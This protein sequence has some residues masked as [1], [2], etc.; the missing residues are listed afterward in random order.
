MYQS[1]RYIPNLKACIEE[2]SFN[3]KFAEEKKKVSAFKFVDVKVEGILCFYY[4]S[5]V[6]LLEV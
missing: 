3:L 2:K 5:V 1:G 4:K 6:S